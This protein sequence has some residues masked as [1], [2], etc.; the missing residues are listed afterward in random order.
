MKQ[1]SITTPPVAIAVLFVIAS[2]TANGF[3]PTQQ[4]KSRATTTTSASTDTTQVG[5]LTVPQIGLGT[6]AWSD[7]NGHNPEL[8]ELMSTIYQQHD[9][10]AFFDTGERYGS[11]A[12]TALGMGWGETELLVAGLL[13]DNEGSSTDNSVVATKFTPSPWR[14]TVQSV[15]EAV[16]IHNGN[17]IDYITIRYRSNQ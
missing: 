12:K 10:A 6:I 3:T 7:N 11:H 14:T 17:F 5:T 1:I 8:E 13:D 4:T 16:S 2:R 9:G 15:V